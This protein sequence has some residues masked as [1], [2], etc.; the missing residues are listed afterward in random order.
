[1]RGISSAVYEFSV[2][3]LGLSPDQSA[4]ISTGLH[5]YAGI[6]PAVVRARLTEYHQRDN[7]AFWFLMRLRLQPDE[8][9]LLA[10]C[11]IP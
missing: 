11:V 4:Q 8:H 1:M 6:T 10:L 3:G 7:N 5:P 9:I 2:S